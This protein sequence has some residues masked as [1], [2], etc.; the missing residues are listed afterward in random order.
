MMHAE[1]TNWMW[2]E[3]SVEALAHEGGVG[4]SQVPS[5]F[6]LYPCIL[7]DTSV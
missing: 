7:S 5:P 1:G 4:I 6:Q 3:K 2:T